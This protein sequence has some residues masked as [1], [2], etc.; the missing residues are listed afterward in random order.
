MNQI[1]ESF[2]KTHIDEYGIT[3]LNK[4]TAFEHFINRLI[5]NKYTVDRFDPE[6]VMTDTG[7]IG[8]DGIGIIVNNILV[9]DADSLNAAIK[10]SSTPDVKFVFVQTKT[11]ESFDGDEIGTFCFGVK[12][13]FAPV[14]KKPKTNEKIEKFVKLKD[15]IYS[16][17]IDFQEPPALEL[18]YVCS[19]KWNDGNNLQDRINFECDYFKST[20]DFSTVNFYPYDNEKIITSYKELKKKISKKF[21]MERKFSFPPMNG[22]KQAYTGLIKCTEFVKILQDSEGN[23][24]NNIF[25]DN[26]RDFQ[27]YNPVNL[28]I[29]KTIENATE[30]E[31]FAVL[32]NGI[33]IIAKNIVPI[34]DEVEIFDYQIVNGCQTSY[35]LFDNKDCIGEN[36]YLLAKIIEVKNESV[37]DRIIYTTNRQT[38]VKSEAFTSAK[39]FHKRLE[40]YFNSIDPKYKLY[41]ERRSKQYELSDGINKNK[42]VTLSTQIYSYISMFLNEPHSTHRYY[43][44]LLQSYSNRIFSDGSLS[45]PYYI[46]AYFTHKVVNEIK[47]KNLS[48]YTKFKFH[49]ICALRAIAVGKDVSAGNSRNLKKKC[50]ELM[51]IISDENQIAQLINTAISCL[52]EAIKRCSNMPYE[53][54][55]RNREFTSCLL[56]VATEYATAKNS[57]QY[58]KKGDIVSC[59]VSSINRSFVYVNIKSEDERSYGS[60]HISN[61]AKKYIS[62]IH[63]EVK[64]SDIIQAK[65]ISD[66]YD[67]K[68][69]WELSMILD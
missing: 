1:I 39:P 12:C 56:D 15:I 61:I 42:V 3:N 4:E 60:I 30:Q 47:A 21:V 62:H 19:G 22:I 37:L 48:K 31:C 5:I 49:I 64:M 17:S 26:V 10:Q 51:N 50:T 63:D 13:F 20:Q 69:G 29:K 35:V 33:T 16:K 59:V 57:T 6:E 43:G 23:M 8:L 45:E 27:G 66:D 18:Y 52:E 14:E 53:N 68:Y 34:G 25:E 65:V 40:D 54:L 11:S 7:E 32:N 44:E 36:V 55:H 24:L 28:E 9:T 41:Y 38:E 2:L 67:S 46:S 58:L